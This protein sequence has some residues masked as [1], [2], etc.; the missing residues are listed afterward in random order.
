M[1]KNKKLLTAF[2]II[3][4]IIGHYFNKLGNIEI[5][6]INGRSMFPSF[7]D[8]EKVCLYNR[9]FTNISQINRW[10]I[11][12]FILKNKWR[13]VKRVM[14]IPWDK[15][16]FWK[17]GYIYINWNKLQEN[18]LASNIH[19]KTNWLKLL[20]TQLEYFNNIIPEWMLLVMWD[21]R[22]VSID[23]SNYWLIHFDQVIW[24]V[25]K[26]FLWKCF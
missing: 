23:S 26:N 19:F 14:A 8:W 11:I 9:Y 15:I 24:K 5:T 6:F 22:W 10:D 25:S 17:D 4:I 3:F 12:G 21:N 2:I 13:I 18:Y 1:S 20:L 16:I 7:S